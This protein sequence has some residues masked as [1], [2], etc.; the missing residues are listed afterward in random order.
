L[1]ATASA[2]RV[3]RRFGG[4]RGA[5]PA[6]TTVLTARARALIIPATT[7]SLLATTLASSLAIAITHDS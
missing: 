7:P 6:T 2:G 4:W 3:A 1:T 5:T